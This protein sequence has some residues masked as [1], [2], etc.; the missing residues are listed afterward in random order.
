M[1]AHARRHA[2][3]GADSAQALHRLF[4]NPQGAERAEVAG[5]VPGVHYSY[6]SIHTTYTW[7]AYYYGV[8]HTFTVEPLE[9]QKVNVEVS[10]GALTS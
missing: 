10:L 6:C 8:G 5:G 2:A 1:V 4:S 7:N 3:A 9:Q